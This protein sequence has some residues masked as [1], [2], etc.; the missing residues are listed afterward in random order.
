MNLTKAEKK[1]IVKTLQAALPYIKSKT[2]WYVCFAI[3]RAFDERRINYEDC[4]LTK[5]YC[6]YLIAPYRSVVLWC[7]RNH[8][9]T[10]YPATWTDYRIAWIDQMI[11][12]LS[13]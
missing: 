13:R 8:E 3:E 10:P 12:E 9:F 4:C 2:D 6:M 11:K 7:D 5:R 1:R